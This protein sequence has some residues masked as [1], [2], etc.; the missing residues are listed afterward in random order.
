[1]ADIE[2]HNDIVDSDSDAEERGTLSGEGWG[3]RGQSTPGYFLPV[4]PGDPGRRG[5]P[6]SPIINL[7]SHCTH[8]Q[9]SLGIFSLENV[10]KMCMWIGSSFCRLRT[11]S[12]IRY[13]I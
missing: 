10:Q 4:L 1:M 2:K 9:G 3:A 13:L 12:H 8:T 7:S 11:F 5:I 6:V